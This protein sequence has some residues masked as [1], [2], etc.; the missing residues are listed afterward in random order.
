M[1]DPMPT[2]WSYRLDGPLHYA[3]IETDRPDFSAVREG[4]V[5]LEFLAG[6]ICGSDIARCLD[7]GTEGHPGVVGLSLHEIVGRVVASNSDLAVGDRVVGWVGQSVGLKEYIE[8]EAEALAPM[9]PDMDEVAAVPLQPLACVLHGLTRIPEDLSGLNVAI[10]GL[11]PVGLFYGHALRD[12]GAAS[13]VGIDL[14]D[15]GAVAEQ[16]G[17]DH[18]EAV[19][20]RAWAKREENVNR[21]D[22]VVEV[23][24]H[25]VGTLQDAITVAAPE[26]TVIYFG[27]PDDRYYPIDFGQ[28]M[29]KHLILQTGRTPQKKRREAMIRAQEYALRYP[30]LF[31]RYITHVFGLDELQTAYE[32]A[33]EPS[34]DRL[35]VILDAR[36]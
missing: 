19:M 3:R 5:I 31:E 2:M 35:K 36:S 18:T 33:A 14:V 7:G 29:D 28:M 17:L 22:L 24:G 6:G 15:R 8:T 4:N 21:F 1:P 25:Q 23:V 16:F 10:I 20:S 32:T 12:R 34:P 11:G 27:N 13:V 9:H 30:D 26:G